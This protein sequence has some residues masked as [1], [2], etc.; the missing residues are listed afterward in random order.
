MRK[1]GANQ[2]LTT[3]NWEKSLSIYQYHINPS[4][5]LAPLLELGK[6]YMICNKV[7]EDLGGKGHR[8][9]DEVEPLKEQGKPST[10]TEVSK[11]VSSRV[12][13]RA[14]FMVV[15]SLPWPPKTKTR[16]QWCRSDGD[17][18]S[19]DRKGGVTLLE[20][21][22]INNGTEAI[23]VQTRGRQRFLVPRGPM[24][25][26]E[27][28]PP[29]DPRPRIID[30]QRPTPAAAIQAVDTATNT[31]VRGATEPGVC[32]LYQKHDPRPELE[33]L[34]ALKPGEPLVRRVNVNKLLS[35]L[36]DSTYGLRMEPRGMWW[37][38]GS[39]EDF[40]A[41]G[42]DRVPQH[43]FQMTIPP[44]MLECKD[45][46]EMQVKNGVAIQCS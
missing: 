23:T 32:G 20:I 42:E 35:S 21:T 19:D 15:P 38:A 30:P 34:V 45:V 39:C 28:Y 43:L 24:Q 1:P 41:E 8:Y 3:E 16:M 6:K 31:F 9:A 37:C 10:L 4:S 12:D 26:E 22:V 7:G 27:E 2:K 5:E 36:P 46:V 40:A 18:I 17:N 29:L 14:T 33:L 44:L 25:P 11:L 13:G